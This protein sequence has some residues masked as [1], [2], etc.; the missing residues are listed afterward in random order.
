M[1]RFAFCAG[2]IGKCEQRVVMQFLQ[3]SN[4]GE[5]LEIFK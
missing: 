2:A 4:I 5:N 3:T 1:T